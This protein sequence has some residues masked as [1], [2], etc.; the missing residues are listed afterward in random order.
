M[1]SKSCD[2]ALS[3]DTA[4]NLLGWK[5]EFSGEGSILLPLQGRVKGDSISPGLRFAAPR[6]TLFLPLPGQQLINFCPGGTS[7]RRWCS[8][9]QPP[10]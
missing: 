3:V 8:A 5:S 10:E 2:F 1:G 7:D 6:A 9:A 4:H